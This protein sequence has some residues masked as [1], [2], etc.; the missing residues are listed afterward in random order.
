MR[1]VPAH[2]LIIG[3]GR[4]ATHLANYFQLLKISY[5]SWSR[6][7]TTE[8]L[9]G[10]AN[11][12]QKILIAIKDS[13]IEEFISQNQLP[14]EK[15]IHFSGA[16]STPL[17]HRLHPLMTFSPTLYELDDYKKIPF[18]GTAGQPALKTLI[19][20]LPN[21]YF[22]LPPGQEELYHALC[23]LGGNGTLVL[24]Q[25]VMKSFETRLN[26][27]KEI[28]NPYLDRICKNLQSDPYGSL[29]GP[30]VRNDI[31]TI[32]KNKNA[33]KNTSYFNLYETLVDTHHERNFQ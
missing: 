2:Y 1:Q 27:P 24:W 25:H 4:L 30:W 5:V 3:R 21:P 22:E 11:H 7:M 15:C 28:L 33:L 9:P 8:A 31:A 20:E 14:A 32:E 10:L 13:A 18:V 12:A 16:L 23:V 26:L 19:P 6:D 29:T 17:A